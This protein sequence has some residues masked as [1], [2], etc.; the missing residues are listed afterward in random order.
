MF[1]G[2]K[3]TNCGESFQFNFLSISIVVHLPPCI[4]NSDIT[5][6]IL[7]VYYCVFNH[8]P[9]FLPLW[10]N[11]SHIFSP[12][13]SFSSPSSSVSLIS[14]P[15]LSFPFSPF[16]LPRRHLLPRFISP[17]SAGDS[18]RSWGIS[19]GGTSVTLP[20]C[21]LCYP[22]LIRVWAKHEYMQEV[23][24]AACMYNKKQDLFSSRNKI[25]TEI[26]QSFLMFCSSSTCLPS[27]T[28]QRWLDPASKR[29]VISWEKNLAFESVY[30]HKYLTVCNVSDFKTQE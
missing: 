24:R 9:E 3:N 29:Q 16:S 30:V 11:P 22:N 27:Q 28:G 19:M 5:L 21:C 26:C 15:S 1:H 14:L 12:S 20:P 18:T 7:I 25:H 2:M 17:P 13:F 6:Y 8:Q 10:E 4:H 23:E